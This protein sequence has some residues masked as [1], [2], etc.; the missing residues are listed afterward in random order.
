MTNQFPQ[1]PPRPTPPRPRWYVTHT[2]RS[3]HDSFPP[4]SRPKLKLFKDGW[5]WMYWI[6]FVPCAL[7]FLLQITFT[8]IELDQ[9]WATLG[10]ASCLAAIEIVVVGTLVLLQAISKGT[11][12][13]LV[14]MSLGWGGMI[15]L[16][17]VASGLS[18]PWMSISDKM[19]WYSA[20]MSMAAAVP[21][22]LV[23]GMGVLVLLW[24]GRAWWNRPWHGLVAGL[25]VG[26]GFGAMENAMYAM[27]FAS[28]DPQSDVSGALSVYGSRIL[29]GPEVHVLMTGLVGYAIGKAL[30]EGPALNISGRVS[31]VIGCFLISMTVHFAWNLQLP[32]D[33]G[34]GELIVYRAVIWCAMVAL[35]VGLIVTSRRRVVPLQRAG[36]EP[37]VTVFIRR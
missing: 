12:K 27:T 7:L 21:E 4:E 9:A 35:I 28:L 18:V 11:P 32:N 23:K 22:E 34:V 19:G 2:P 36:L 17:S 8:V 20:S 24:I 10:I 5:F 15:A 29:L 33:W 31:T 13:R 14:A 30:Y 3:F 6:L 1:Q 16:M 26:L 25:L 37:A